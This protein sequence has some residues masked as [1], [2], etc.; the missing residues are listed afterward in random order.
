MRI[1]QLSKI[2]PE[3]L[4]RLADSHE[5]IDGTGVEQSRVAELIEGCTAVLMRS[6]LSV[7]RVE[8]NAA[9]GLR[10]IVRAGSGF[11]NID[12][13][14]AWR[15]GVRV[16]RIPGPAAQSV[17]ELALGLAFAVARKIV[18]AD[19]TMRAG[20]WRKNDI[21]GS[22]VSDKTVGIVGLGSIG[23]RFAEMCVALGATVIGCVEQ[24]SQLAD[25]RFASKGIRLTDFEETLTGS[26][27]LSIHVPLTPTT[28]GLLST[29]ELDSMKP[30]SLLINTS[31]G[32]VV[33]EQALAAVLER[34]YPLAGAAVDVHMDESGGSPLGHLPNVV[35]TPHIG[36]TARETQK[37]IGQRIME[38]LDAFLAGCLDDLLD[39][40]ERVA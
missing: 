31:R 39:D 18:W 20:E 14:Y 21:V 25:K 35:L 3:T 28:L 40:A 13:E 10:L 6:G 23:T 7:G 16:I 22:L 15:R 37:A 11:D 34:S 17:A 33:D 9:P 24:P 2:D 32:G 29:K 26:D 4:A 19:Q 5:I 12:V 8:L 27:L 38:I 1:L 30:G 36:S